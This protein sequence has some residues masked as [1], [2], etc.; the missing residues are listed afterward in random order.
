MT[1]Y[2]LTTNNKHKTLKKEFTSCQLATDPL[3]EIILVQIHYLTDIQL[4]YP[5][6]K[7]S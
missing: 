4:S 5:T 1:S 6:V 2:V 7:K 3:K